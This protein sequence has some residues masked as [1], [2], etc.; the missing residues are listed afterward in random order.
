MCGEVVLIPVVV[1]RRKAQREIGGIDVQFLRGSVEP[2]SHMLDEISL[3][4][5]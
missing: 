3:A 2:L 4:M 1:E 5:H